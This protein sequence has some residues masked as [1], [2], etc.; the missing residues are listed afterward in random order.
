MLSA[1]RAEDTWCALYLRAVSPYDTYVINCKGRSPLQLSTRHCTTGLH[2]IQTYHG[3]I[4]AVCE[5]ENS[6]MQV[7]ILEEVSR[8][9]L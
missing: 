1:A 6:L 2:N 3:D 7:V 5:R 8:K 4:F 9:H